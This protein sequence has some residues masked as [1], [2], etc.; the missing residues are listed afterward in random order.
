M[1]LNVD[2]C[3]QIGLRNEACVKGGEWIAGNSVES[4]EMIF[5]DKLL[6]VFLESLHGTSDVFDLASTSGLSNIKKFSEAVA[7]HERFDSFV[8]IA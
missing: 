3:S 7:I 1:N 4:A 6:D 2:L 8:E 5:H